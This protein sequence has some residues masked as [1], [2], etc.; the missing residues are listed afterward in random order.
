VL[1]AIVVSQKTKAGVIAGFL[2][3]LSLSVSVLTGERM[4][5]LIRACGG[6]LAG[7]VWKPKFF[8]YSL[9]IIIEVMAV[10]AVI[11]LRPDLS[12]RFGKSF[13]EKIPIVNSDN[14]NEH[15]GAWRGGIQ[16]G[17]L[18][19][20]KGIGPSGTR[21][22]CAQLD[23]NM[24]NWLPG[25]NYCGN[26]PHNF[27]IQLFSETGIIGL[28]LGC[29]MFTTIVL[30][31]Y[32]AR[33][34]NFECPMSATAF[35]VPFAFFFPLQQFGSFYGQWGNLF[36]WFAIGFAISNY[37]GWRKSNRIFEK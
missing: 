1:I 34:E 17:L 31:C 7:L 22:T 3:L 16:Q 37:Q 21:K 33:K 6:M 13:I 36:M 4:N 15:W 30:T 27:Y 12:D 20:Y 28:I 8:L 19:P 9:L 35:V 26:H 5:F 29:L 25:K 14:S 11:F 32:K 2:G 24:P 10:L 18:T 23:K